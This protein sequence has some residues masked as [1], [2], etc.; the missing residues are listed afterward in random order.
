MKYNKTYI[1]TYKYIKS[2]KFIQYDIN[3]ARL[4]LRVGAGFLFSI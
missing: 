1:C 4:V 3:G 2:L